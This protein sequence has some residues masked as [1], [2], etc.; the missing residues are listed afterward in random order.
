MKLEEYFDFL[1]PLD[2]RIKGHRIGIDDVL[3]YYLRGYQPEAILEQYPSL[4]LAEIEAVIAYY[5]RNQ[6]Q[7]DRYLADQAAW[8]EERHQQL[9]ADPPPVVH[10]IRERVQARTLR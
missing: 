9:M 7:M 1:D 6:V 3:Y 8:V 2:I 5:H 10:R 4:S